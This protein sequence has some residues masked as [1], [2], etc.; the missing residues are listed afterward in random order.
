MDVVVV[1]VVA[2]VIYVV[3]HMFSHAVKMIVMFIL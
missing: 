1:V 3:L 2:G